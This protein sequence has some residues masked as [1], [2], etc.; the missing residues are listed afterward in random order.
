M[1]DA[2][3]VASVLILLLAAASVG[4]AQS[5]TG[6]VKGFSGVTFGDTRS[7][8]LF[9]GGAGASIASNV[10]IVGEAGYMRDTRPSGLF[11]SLLDLGLSAVGAEIR[12]PAW[13]GEGGVRFLTS[14]ASV[15]RGYVE[16]TAGVARLTTRVDLGSELDA[17]ES[18]VNRA[19]GGIESTNGL[20]GFGA[21]IVIQPGP[22]LLD[23]GYR[24]KR[25]YTDDPFNL[26]QVRAAIGVA[27]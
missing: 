5:R 4:E 26:N 11:T 10:Q 3:R 14:D 2:I 6:F 16:T 25:I 15:V 22:L 9:G 17:V 24:Y 27:F 1:R 23:I 13:Y 12:V 7:D 18:I 19:L 21:G 8:L 20:L